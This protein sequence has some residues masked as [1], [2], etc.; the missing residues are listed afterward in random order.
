MR[1]DNGSQQDFPIR[2]VVPV[3][4]RRAQD[5]CWARWG[6]FSMKETMYITRDSTCTCNSL[7]TICWGRQEWVDGSGWYWM[8]SLM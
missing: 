6:G 3:G 8:T 7:L 4:L 2:Q 1:F 5:H